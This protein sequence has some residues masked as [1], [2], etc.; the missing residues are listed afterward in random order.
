MNITISVSGV[1]ILSLKADFV[2]RYIQ[3]NLKQAIELNRID[4]EKDW[5]KLTNSQAVEILRG[6]EGLERAP[7][8]FALEDGYVLTV[9]NLIKM[10]SIQ[11]RLKF[12]LP[13]S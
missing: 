2:R 7:G 9:D 3:G 10:L 6:V 5:S 1:N 4:L 8:S 11:L 13:V 12:G